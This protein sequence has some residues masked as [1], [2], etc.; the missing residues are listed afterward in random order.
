MKEI[1]NHKQHLAVTFD[2]LVDLLFMPEEFASICQVKSEAAALLSSRTSWVKTSD[3]VVEGVTTEKMVLIH[4]LWFARIGR[5]VIED[6]DPFSGALFLHFSFQD[7][8]KER[9]LLT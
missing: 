4:L 3:L 5:I 1:T 9:T 8:E 2:R 6:A 7:V